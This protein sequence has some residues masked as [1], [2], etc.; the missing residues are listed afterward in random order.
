MF[1]ELG[2][3]SSKN[4]LCSLYCLKGAYMWE[5]LVAGQLE[6]WDTMSQASVLF[7]WLCQLSGE[8]VIRGPGAWRDFVISISVVLLVLERSHSRSGCPMSQIGGSMIGSVSCSRE[9]WET[10]F[11]LHNSYPLW[12]WRPLLSETNCGS[13]LSGSCDGCIFCTLCA[14]PLVSLVKP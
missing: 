1:R 13:K 6:F 12:Q 4:I 2:I 3:V 10:S 7:V 5:H 9:K 8:F 14:M 11:S